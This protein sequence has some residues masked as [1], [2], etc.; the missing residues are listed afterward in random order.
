MTLTLKAVVRE[1]VKKRLKA[2]QLRTSGKEV[3]EEAEE[4]LPLEPVTRERLEKA[5]LTWL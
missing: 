4:T 5:Q 1:S 3:T 2:V